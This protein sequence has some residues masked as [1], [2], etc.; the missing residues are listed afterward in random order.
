VT[1]RV[2]DLL[3]AVDIDERDHKPFAGPASALQ[4]TLEL[5]QARSAPSDVGQLIDL[6]RLAVKRGLNP[7]ARRHQTITRGLLAFGGCPEP[8]GCSIG[9]IVCS[10]PAIT[11]DPQRLLSHHRTIPRPSAPVPPLSSPVALPSY[12][13]AL[14]GRE[15]PRTRR[16]QTSTSLPDS[17]LS[18][19]LTSRAK[20]A[21][22]L[23]TGSRR[24][25]P[26]AGNL[27]LIGGQ[28]IIV[29]RRLVLIRRRLILIGGRLVP[30]R[31]RLIFLGS[32]PV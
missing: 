9:A 24:Q 32:R 18:R 15:T 30:L 3:Q 27:I 4:F 16:I 7:L 29:G 21:T 11:R 25:F 19:V 8:I 26:I 20:L 28:L 5:F 23:R 6:G 13:I 31:S 2:V 10:P 12:P 17:H 1:S 22:Y 14:I